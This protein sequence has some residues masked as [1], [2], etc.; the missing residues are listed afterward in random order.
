MPPSRRDEVTGLD[1]LRSSLYS[2][3][4]PT[5]RWLSADEIEQIIF[6]ICP[7]LTQ[8]AAVEKISFSILP[9]PPPSGGR[10]TISDEIEQ[11][12]SFICPKL[13]KKAAIEK[14]SF[15]ILQSPLPSGGRRAILT[16]LSKLFSLFSQTNKP[17]RL[18]IRQTQYGFGTG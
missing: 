12:L 7:N 2:P 13:P 16:K 9:S 6:S 17:Y 5:I 8:K 4:S 3:Q 11:I 1:E 14:I 10:R 18:E 15:F